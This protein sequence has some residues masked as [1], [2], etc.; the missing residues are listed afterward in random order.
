MAKNELH[1]YFDD[2]WST[3]DFTRNIV[4]RILE[5]YNCKK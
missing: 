1:S 2:G 4:D 5:Q 3:I